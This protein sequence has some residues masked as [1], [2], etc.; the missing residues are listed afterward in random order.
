MPTGSR[1]ISIFLG[2]VLR[3]VGGVAVSIPTLMLWM[4]SAT[5]LRRRCYT[6]GYTGLSRVRSFCCS[7]APR[8]RTRGLLRDTRARIVLSRPVRV[9]EVHRPHVLDPFP[10]Q[11]IW[12]S[13]C[14]GRGP[15][16]EGG[17]L[18]YGPPH[19]ACTR[20]PHTHRGVAF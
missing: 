10:P 19:S 18:R 16:G 12:P 1:L 14:F 6:V 4:I 11:S 7:R 3:R 8:N 13:T 17:R 2:S 20:L 5:G 15:P 9:I